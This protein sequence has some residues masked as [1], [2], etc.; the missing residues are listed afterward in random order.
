MLYF[1]PFN[2][3]QAFMRVTP[4]LS[5][6]FL[7]M[8]LPSGGRSGCHC[9]QP[10]LSAGPVFCFP[11]VL[12]LTDLSHANVLFLFR[13]S[14]LTLIWVRSEEYPAQIF[15]PSSNIRKGLWKLLNYLLSNYKTLRLYWVGLI[16]SHIVY[17]WCRPLPTSGRSINSRCHF[18]PWDLKSFKPILLY[19]WPWWK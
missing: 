11:P 4:K 6:S 16:F 8:L 15:C 1:C 2:T 3:R 19:C 10:Y 17:C 7:S 9:M 14:T 12:T 13:C 5:A 18:L